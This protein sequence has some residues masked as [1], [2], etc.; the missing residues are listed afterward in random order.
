MYCSQYS[1]YR[2]I[3]NTFLKDLLNDVN[4]CMMTSKKDDIE[5]TETGNIP[6]DIVALRE[7]A[8][9]EIEERKASKSLTMPTDFEPTKKMLIWLNY[10]VNN[11]NNTNKDIAR[12][13]N[14]AE[15]TLYEWR[16]NPAF[17]R[18]Y[19]AEWDKRLIMHAPKL[20]QIG[21][22]NSDGN[23]KYWV[24]MQQRVG[25]LEQQAV[26]LQNNIQMNVNFL[27]DD[28]KAVEETS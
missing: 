1:T 16:K 26:K 23:Y 4:G 11:P 7:Q 25:N 24:S 14:I 15:Q 8:S 13:T 21:L 3:V 19:K 20:D 12:A 9:A 10:E 17:L 5:T 2:Y 27:E 18:W 22:K 6:T 28:G